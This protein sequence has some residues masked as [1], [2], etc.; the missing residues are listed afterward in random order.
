MELSLSVI[1]RALAGDWRRSVVAL[2]ALANVLGTLGCGAGAPARSPGSAEETLVPSPSR[3]V[4]PL[5][6]SAP[7]PLPAARDT[8]VRPGRLA[9]RN[10][11]SAGSLTVNQ[12]L[13]GF[14]QAQLAALVPANAEMESAILEVTVTGAPAGGA[15]PR[16][17][18]FRLTQD[19][20]ER[21]ATWDCADDQ[22]PLDGR[23]QCAPAQRWNLSA[24]SAR[25]G[26]NPWAGLATASA[27]VP[28]PAPAT[29]SF[30]VSADVAAFL[31]GSAPNFGWILRSDAADTDIVAAI[32]ARESAQPPRL[33]VTTRCRASFADCDGQPDNGCEQPLTA[34]ESCGA[35]G[36]SCDDHDPC[37]ADSCAAGGCLHDAAAV[38][39]ASCDDG[40]LCT[41]A[42]TCRA[43]A[44]A[45][46]AVTCDDGDQCHAAGT[47]DPA[48][49]ACASAA[50]VDGTPCSDGNACTDGDRCVAGVCQA[51]AP[52][53][54]AAS[55]GC[56]PGAC[57]PQSGACS[58]LAA[59]QLYGVGSVPGKARD[60]LALTPARLEDGTPNDQV[61][62]LGSAITYT[63]VGNLYLAA[64]D[65]GPGAGADSFSER[66]YLLDVALAGGLV[67]PVIRGAAVLDPGAGLAPFTGL[68][69]A[70]DALNSPASRRLDVEAIRAGAQGTFFVSDEYGP[71]LYEFGADGHRRRALAVPG[72]FLIDH[73]GI[74][75]AELPP[76]NLAGRQANRGMEG[77]AISPDGGKLYGILQSPLIQDGA[78]SPANDR[79]GTNIRILEIDVASGATRELLYPLASPAFGVNEILAVNDHQFLVLERDGKAGAAAVAKRLYLIDIAGASDV[80]SIAALPST[81][82]PDGVTPVG[83]NLFLDLLDPAFALAG[84]SFPEKIEGLAFGP[85]LPDG[86]HLLLVSSD[87]DFV[88]GQASQIYAF[89]IDPRALPLWQPQKVA[90][91][92]ACAEATPDSC[93]ATGPCSLSG[94]CQPGDGSC[95]T[96]LVAAGTP[97]GA[98]SAGD[99]RRVQCDGAGQS[100]SVADDGDVPASDDNPCTAE[101]CAAGAAASAPVAAGTPC[102]D[103]RSQVCDGAGVCVA[104]VG[105][106]CPGTEP[107]AAPPTFRVV[108]VGDAGLALSAAAAPVFVEE[109][110]IDGTL[111]ATVALPTAAAG[112][113][114]P[115][116][117]SGSASSEGA[118][119]LSADG[120]WLA[121]AGYA[122]APGTASIAATAS[123]TVNRV[124]ARVDALGNVDTTTALPAAFNANNVRGAVGADGSGFWVAGAG[125][126]TGGVWFV[127]LGARA[128]LQ[129]A[130]N[131][132]SVRWPLIFD[133]QLYA[134][135]SSGAFVNVFTVG[136][137]L[138]REGGQSNL[139][140]P[141]MPVSGSASPFGF[142]LLDLD[143]TVA[144]GDTL[145]VA[146]DRAAASGG[147]VQKWTLGL[148][149]WTLAATFNLAAGPIGFR[150]LAGAIVD[151]HP[152]LLA[153]SADASPRLVSFVDDGAGA[154]VLGTVVATPAA[155]TVFRGVAVSPR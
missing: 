77:L 36:L 60:G 47:C 87:N 74:E 3:G 12:A 48:T 20:S 153:T 89:A 148:A 27:T 72:K 142:V 26:P 49:G 149:G 15:A 76:G 30:D 105:S 59:C 143:A 92:T 100:V 138:P 37:T 41:Q 115:L 96:P 1:S 88:T 106:G 136:S 103:D 21:G 66:Y 7:L 38:E 135:A 71:F 56:H 73:P 155:N 145:Y 29:L 126:A 109:R 93:P 2:L 16:I 64:P 52:V 110:Q 123:A 84:A 97:V 14:D 133:G 80:S 114:L 134:S 57:D 108:R 13:V 63:G 70:F 107:P 112:D 23:E 139:P 54:C 81:G 116:V 128:G 75:D 69:S 46:I 8:F 83:K 17:D 144:G 94:A 11:G 146:D 6:V 40:D 65:R 152:T 51:V 90:F 140:L 127:L 118:L 34:A 125:G 150:G 28:S 31:A 18:L 120:H 33:R 43:G 32:G 151:G 129:V 61:G 117:M 24:A 45:G 68:A 154:P 121:L 111:V 104:C 5:P 86:R 91:A 147:G 101:L 99:C 95:S 44:C 137:G 131:P 82:V 39:G 119:S 132:A 124:V 22:R 10:F 113:N 85:D 4:G 19:W 9:D 78:L 141:G 62:G 50:L 67:T 98:Q 79:V 53:V 122:A 58:N 130:G 55:D 102:S 42:D 25:R 35:C